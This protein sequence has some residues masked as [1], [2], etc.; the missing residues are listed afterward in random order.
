VCEQ[1]AR[2]I[3]KIDVAAA[4][5]YHVIWTIAKSLGHVASAFEL[6][7]KYVSAIRLRP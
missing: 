1:I 2:E 6:N 3:K 5:L 7:L 4:L